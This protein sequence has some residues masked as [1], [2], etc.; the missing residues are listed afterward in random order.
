MITWLKNL[1]WNQA[2]FEQYVRTGLAGFWGAYEMGLIP[3]E[4]NNA[5]LWYLTRVALVLAFVL[6]AGEKNSQT[7]LKAPTNVSET[8]SRQYVGE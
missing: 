5:W 3:G 6:R 1:L 8:L 4:T 7:A 2:T